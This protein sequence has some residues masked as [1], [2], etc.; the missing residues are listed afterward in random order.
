[1]A[2]ELGCLYPPI[3]IQLVDLLKRIDANDH[4]IGYIN[5]H[6][7]P[8]GAKRLRVAELV[9][10]NLLAFTP[11]PYVDVPR[12]TKELRLPAF[13]YPGV[14]YAWPCENRLKAQQQSAS[15]PCLGARSA[16][17]R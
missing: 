12:I 14:R 2:E 13:E 11:K 6:A 4:Q 1:M 15:R 10:R 16:S 7:L 5:D 3:V 17:P 8:S 9:T